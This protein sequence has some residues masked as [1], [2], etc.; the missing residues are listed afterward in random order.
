MPAVLVILAWSM[1]NALSGVAQEPLNDSARLLRE[2]FERSRDATRDWD[3][4]WY[5]FGSPEIVDSEKAERAITEI[6]P[7]LDLFRRAMSG[8]RPQYASHDANP[9]VPSPLMLE[10]RHLSSMLRTDLDYRLLRGETAGVNDDLVHLVELSSF[11]RDDASILGSLV[12]V[13]AFASARVQIENAIGRGVL[14]QQ[15]AQT[16][17]DAVDETIEPDTHGLIAGVENDR[18]RGVTWLHEQNASDESR[19]EM[20]DGF[21]SWFDPATQ[22]EE[23]DHLRTMSQ[24]DVEAAIVGYDTAMERYAE[25]LK[26][27]SFDLARVEAERLERDIQSGLFGPFAQHLGPAGISR[28]V[29][30]LEIET[31][32]LQSLR[33]HLKEIATD[34]DAAMRLRNA[35]LIYEE[36]FAVF[37][38]LPFDVRDHFDRTPVSRV[39]GP[40]RRLREDEIA[41]G[42]RRSEIP[43][44]EAIEEVQPIINLLHEASC[45]ERCEFDQGG[46]RD[47]AGPWPWVAHVSEMRTCAEILFQ[48]TAC[49]E[50]NALTDRG[51]RS[52]DLLSLLAMSQHMAQ[53]GTFEGAV[54]SIEIADR[55]LPLFRDTDLLQ[56]SE[57][58]E[59][60]AERFFMDDPFGFRHAIRKHGLRA[61]KWPTGDFTQPHTRES[62]Q[63]AGAF[64]AAR[65]DF[66]EPE[67]P[68]ILAREIDE[69]SGADLNAAVAHLKAFVD[70]WSERFARV[71]GTGEVDAADIEM[72]L[73]LTDAATRMGLERW[74]RVAVRP[75]PMAAREAERSAAAWM[76]LRVALDF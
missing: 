49:A 27:D 16:I 25:I 67:E 54:L 53:D 15:A 23:L 42:A 34:P 31:S 59:A 39:I 20:I 12:D 55:L 1:S 4:E 17:L 11:P 13:A 73:A 68:A 28:M 69:M 75:L 8:E 26:G 36:A 30:T 61:K 19:A 37:R 66:V 38:R 76:E 24:G 41:E 40:A 74:L 6:R 43:L 65:T 48:R 9:F 58:A 50:S 62:M 64:L 52:A 7:A 72:E 46:T 56:E 14:D 3:D 47:L 29:Q 70:T 32:F 5:L 51:S 35:A 44:S 45:I 2:A 22:L 57:R 18:T 60:I 21:A 10:F 33:D 63:A 71:R